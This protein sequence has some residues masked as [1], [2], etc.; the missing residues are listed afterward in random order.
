MRNDMGYQD[1]L[2]FLLLDDRF[3][4]RILYIYIALYPLL[5]KSHLLEKEVR[6][7]LEPCR[8]VQP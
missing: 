6:E 5:L 2:M 7:T 8:I 3:L 4:P 1:I